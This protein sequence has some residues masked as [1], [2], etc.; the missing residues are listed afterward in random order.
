MRFACGSLQA[1][2]F[3]ADKLSG[4]LRKSEQGQDP[5]RPSLDS[6]FGA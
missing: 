1:P 3:A 2:F 6:P 4:S 5:I